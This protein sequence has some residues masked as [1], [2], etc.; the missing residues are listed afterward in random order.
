MKQINGWDKSLFREVSSD[1]TSKSRAAIRRKLERIRHKLMAGG[2]LTAE[3]KAFLRRYAPALYDLAMA[4]ERER[5]AY[6]ERLKNCRT[7][8]E[9]GPDHDGEDGSEMGSAREE[10]AETKIMRMAQIK[11]AEKA[12]A[13][14][15]NK[16]PS[17]VEKDKKKQKEEQER[18]EAKRKRDRKKAARERREKER[19]EKELRQEE[20]EEEERLKEKQENQY[21]ERRWGSFTGVRLIP[22]QGKS[23][24]CGEAR[25]RR[26]NLRRWMRSTDFLIREP[27][28]PCTTGPAGFRLCQR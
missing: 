18:I 16:K 19:V 2:R 1:K 17:Q 25:G 14:A 10:D 11:A 4:M 15:V 3:E 5:A 28:I 24:H 27:G 22:W 23:G 7:K 20:Y 8:E 6:E 26:W 21:V 12:T 13:A 9:A